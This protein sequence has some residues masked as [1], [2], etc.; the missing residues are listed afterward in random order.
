M[1]SNVY[2]LTSYSGAVILLTFLSF[3]RLP[4]RAQG[5]MWAEDGNVFVAGA[6]EPNDAW[7]PFRPYAGYLHVVPRLAAETVVRVFPIEDYALAMSLLACAAVAVV[8]VL[9]YHCAHAITENVWMRVAW[10][11]IPVLV[12]VGAIE[13]LGNFANFHWYLLWL[14]PWLLIKPAKST[15]GAV[16][17]FLFAALTSLTEIISVVFLPLFIFRWRDKNYWPARAGLSLGLACQVY[18]TMTYP[19]ASS[20]DHSLDPLSVVYGWFINTAGP[21]VYGNSRQVMQQIINFGAAPVI[22][23]SIIVAAA[24]A[25][26]LALGT[27]RERRLAALFVAASVIVWAACVLAN[28]AHYLDYA[29]F[30]DNDWREYFLFSRYSVAPTMFMLGIA[31]ILASAVSRISPRAPIAVL[32]AFALLLV[33]MYFPPA[34]RRDE[35]PVWAENV[36]TGRDLCAAG[37]PADYFAVPVAPDFYNG[38]VDFSCTVLLEK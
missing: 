19:R 24:I 22:V 34:T 10:A 29:S 14:T 31:P 7:T 5:V 25:T 4:Q 16:G 15:P 30:S 8:S 37:L 32:M 33:S 35:G 11:A 21:I 28:P 20:G 36:K 38:H 9:T 3:W 1:K 13:T 27:R 23:A 12:N 2:R 26:I 17:L 6:L 18:T